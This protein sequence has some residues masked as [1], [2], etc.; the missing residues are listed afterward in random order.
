VVGRLGGDE[1]AVILVQAEAEAAQAKADALV[2]LI[3][4]EPVVFEGRAIA[5]GASAGVRA[6]EPSLDPARWLA[7]ADAAMFVAKGL[8]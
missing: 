8:R 4:A 5:L 1:F 6:W 7:E 2:A 3:A